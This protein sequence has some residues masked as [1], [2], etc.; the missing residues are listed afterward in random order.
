MNKVCNFCGNKNFIEKTVQYVY[1]DNGRF[2]IFNDVPC[3]E[4]EFCGE[5]YFE[6]SVLK[7]IEK[8]FDDVYS[9]QKKAP[10]EIRVPVEQYV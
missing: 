3:E 1:Q 7:K 2:M 10:S 6:A 4:C 8:E 5:R 9:K